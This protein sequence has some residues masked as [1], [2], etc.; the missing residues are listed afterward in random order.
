MGLALLAEPIIALIFQHGRFTAF[1]TGQTAAALVFYSFGL[2]AYSGVKVV[3][4]VFYALNNTRY[5]VLGSFLAVSAN[6]LFIILTLDRF[7]H[8]AIA[9]A[10]SLSMI[11]NFVFLSAVLYFQVQGYPLRRIFSSLAKIC[12]AAG[13]MGGVV[14][15]MAAGLAAHLSDGILGRLALVGSVMTAGMLVYGISLYFLKI[16]EF[17][18]ILR[19]FRRLGRKT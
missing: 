5:P 14:Y 9:L 2:F 18:D 4:P 15:S 16:P 17:Q 8:R 13:C 19:Q 7:Q 6:F 3:V 10:T 11:L 12:L 1:D